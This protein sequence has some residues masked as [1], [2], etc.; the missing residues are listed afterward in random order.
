MRPQP[1]LAIPVPKNWLDIAGHFGEGG[2]VASAGGAEGWREHV[3]AAEVCLVAVEAKLHDYHDT[4]DRVEELNMGIHTRGY[5]DFSELVMETVM[6]HEQVHHLALCRIAF[7]VA[8]VGPIVA[9][10]ADIDP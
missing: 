10:G 6:A 5:D 1:R 2:S 8:K 9:L 4:W 3:E 7:A